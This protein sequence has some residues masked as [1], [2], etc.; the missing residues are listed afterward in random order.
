MAIVDRIRFARM[1]ERRALEEL[2]RRAS[3]IWDEYRESLLEH[4]EAIALPAEQIRARQVRVAERG[5]L[6]L[7]FSA[8]LGPH[9]GAAELDGLFVEPARMGGGVGR[10]LI[11]DAARL[12]RRRG[13]RVLEVTGNPRALGFYVKVG[14]VATGSAETQFGPGIR[15][16]L[17][18][19]R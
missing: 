2:Q 16:R 12:A 4:P 19:G 5:G 14:F 11:A 18:L 6:A 7:G 1:A 17:A 10:L 8:V 13:A 3:L 9:D 15:M